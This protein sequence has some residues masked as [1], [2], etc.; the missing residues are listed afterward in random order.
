M[1]KQLCCLCLATWAK[2]GA[3]IVIAALRIVCWVIHCLSFSSLLTL[4]IYV[5]QQ[6]PSRA[7]GKKRLQKT[8]K[9]FC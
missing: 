9:I 7:W 8:N 2:H 6:I 3:G 4:T 1:F 5:R